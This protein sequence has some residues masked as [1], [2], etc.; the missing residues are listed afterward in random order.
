MNEMTQLDIGTRVRGA[1]W[2][3]LLGPG[4]LERLGGIGAIRKALPSTVEVCDVASIAMIRAG[5]TPELGDKNRKLDTPL[6]RALAR[7]L[8]PITLF[9]EVDLLS[10]FANFDEDLLDRWER[11]F[12]D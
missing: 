5:K 10:H 3:T 6:L 2:V 7:V 8:E 12:L 4:P 9:R 1:R 11:R